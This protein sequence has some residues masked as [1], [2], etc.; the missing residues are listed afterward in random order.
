MSSETNG[1]NGVNEAGAAI[2]AGTLKWIFPINAIKVNT[3]FD[4]AA[5]LAILDNK[6]L[7]LDD[8][9][10]QIK[11]IEDAE[12][13]ANHESLV[14]MVLVRWPRGQ[15][16]LR[17]IKVAIDALGVSMPTISVLANF[18]GNSL[19]ALEAL[20]ERMALGENLA[21]EIEFFEDKFSVNTTGKYIYLKNPESV[22]LINIHIVE[23]VFKTN[24]EADAVKKQ[25]AMIMNRINNL[26]INK[27]TGAGT[28]TQS[29]GY[30]GA[31]NV[32]VASVGSADDI[33]GIL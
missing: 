30:A 19:L 1:V 14:P 33:D 8:K 12:K 24:E 23:P 4:H 21:I 20:Q 5:L 28:V 32:D 13:A 10:E 22:D 31:D 25:R 26:R 16:I 17:K 3:T 9:L 11:E 15:G 6:E 7:T 27:I 18:D 2:E 29:G